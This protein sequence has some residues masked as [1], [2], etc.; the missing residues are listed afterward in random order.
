GFCG[1]DAATQQGGHRDRFAE[2]RS[3]PLLPR[4]VARTRMPH[5]TR[6]DRLVKTRAG[7]NRTHV[8]LTNALTSVHQPLLPSF[9][10]VTRKNQRHWWM[11]ATAQVTVKDEVLLCGAWSSG[12]PF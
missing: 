7:A 2:G 5:Q 12:G 8:S 3:I 1:G 10:V 9:S 11:V 6:K 4:T